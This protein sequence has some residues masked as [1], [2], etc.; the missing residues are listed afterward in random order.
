MSQWAWDYSLKILNHIMPTLWLSIQ[1]IKSTS[2]FFTKT[3]IPPEPRLAVLNNGRQTLY[4]IK[5]DPCPKFWFS[6]S[7]SRSQSKLRYHYYLR[8][9]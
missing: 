1:H 4:S 7:F 3:V 6:H 9:L 2:C 5:S 8:C